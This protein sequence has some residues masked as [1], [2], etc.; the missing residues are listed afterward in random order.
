MD[1]IQTVCVCLQLVHANKCNVYISE[2]LSMAFVFRSLIHLT[3][4]KT[5]LNLLLHFSLTLAR[6]RCSV[7]YKE[8]KNVERHRQSVL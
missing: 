8:I 1:I 6:K 4:L 2:K 7:R 5:G 3:Q